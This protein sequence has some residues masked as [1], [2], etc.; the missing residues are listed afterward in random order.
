MKPEDP[1]DPQDLSLLSQLG[2]LAAEE[3]A[4]SPDD[5]ELEALCAGQLD[6]ERV[7]LLESRAAQD[8]ELAIRLAAYRPLDDDRRAGIAEAIA[9]ATAPAAQRAER[10]GLPALGKPRVPGARKRALRAWFT[11]WA[12]VGEIAL[13]AAA[14]LLWLHFRPATNASASLPTYG[15]DVIGG[16]RELRDVSAP[17]L[18]GAVVRLRPDSRVDLILRPA[19]ATAE[20]IAVEASLA[21]G[22]VVEPLPLRFEI[23]AGGA[24]R[25]SGTAAELFGA[26]R[27]RWQLRL[28][29]ARGDGEAGDR[30]RRSSGDSPADGARRLTL[31]LLLLDA[32]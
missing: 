3:E 28:V 32:R 15:V 4:L 31:E 26:R 25:A 24:A 14:A 9:R 21:Q 29:V 18:E 7:R 27:G 10:A 2:R 19:T 23:A 11:G 8:P 5:R 20:P 1:G 6:E 12:A 22:G 13:V 30:R 17:A 16:E